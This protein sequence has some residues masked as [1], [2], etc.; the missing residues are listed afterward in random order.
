MLHNWLHSSGTAVEYSV[1][2]ALPSVQKWAG[3]Q[4]YPHHMT[5]LPSS[6]YGE[7]GYGTCLFH[8]HSA[9]QNVGGPIR[10]HCVSDIII[11]YRNNGSQESWAIEAVCR[12]L[13]LREG[14]QEFHEWLGCVW[15]L[16]NWQWKVWMAVRLLQSLSVAERG[17]FP[18]WLFAMTSLRTALSCATEVPLVTWCHK[19]QSY[20]RYVTVFETTENENGIGCSPDQFSL[21]G[22]KWSGNKNNCGESISKQWSE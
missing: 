13:G 21:C 9:R 3:S 2:Q 19:S 5:L 14:C 10:L 15:E 4:D 1:H 20:K 17:F 8:S 7:R 11:L 6:F 12:R 18:G 22:E 16:D